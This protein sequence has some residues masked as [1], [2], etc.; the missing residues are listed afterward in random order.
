MRSQFFAVLLVLAG[1]NPSCLS[2]EPDP[3][4]A[5]S[6]PVPAAPVQP[7]IPMPD[8][9]SAAPAS[10]AS[11]QP[12]VTPPTPIKGT[13]ATTI[14]WIVYD[15]SEPLPLRWAGL[16]SLRSRRL[17]P[18][19]EEQSNIL[20]ML[21]SVA[22]RESDHPRVRLYCLGIIDEYVTGIATADKER[23]QPEFNQ[24][25]TTCAQILSSSHT[26]DDVRIAAAQISAK[27]FESAAENERKAYRDAYLAVLSNPATLTRVRE[28]LMIVTVPN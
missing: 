19:R 8:Q 15:D 1:S 22:V 23:M 12:A 7:A 21:S 9:E 4:T 28:A 18:S 17:G 20:G 2:Q 3:T 16:E 25:L 10:S 27:H 13:A 11:T 24:F 26:D 14:G 5:P 6:D